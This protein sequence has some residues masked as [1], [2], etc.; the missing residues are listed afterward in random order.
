MADSRKSE[1]CNHCGLVK[2]KPC[3]A[4]GEESPAEKEQPDSLV[5]ESGDQL[6]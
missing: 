4:N 3:S 2:G 1:V 5:F 6:G